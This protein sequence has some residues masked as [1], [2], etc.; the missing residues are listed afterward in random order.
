M[1]IVL[2]QGGGWGGVERNMQQYPDIDRTLIG[3]LVKLGYTEGETEDILRALKLNASTAGI[4]PDDSGW[5]P[6]MHGSPRMYV[7]SGLVCSMRDGLI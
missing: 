1:S 6:W 4:E 7:M 3:E 2:W 5:F